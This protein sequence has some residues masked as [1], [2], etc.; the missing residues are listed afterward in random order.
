M[1]CLHQLVPSH[2]GRF[3]L[4]PGFARSEDYRSQ[5]DHLKETSSRVARLLKE[6]ARDVLLGLQLSQLLITLSPQSTVLS[7]ARGGG[8]VNKHRKT[9]G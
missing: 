9:A 8:A 4:I 5:S 7:N 3:R 1:N 6:A 2:S